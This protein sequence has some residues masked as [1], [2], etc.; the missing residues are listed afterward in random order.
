MGFGKIAVA[1][2]AAAA[3]ELA[4]YQVAVVAPTTV[5]ARQHL[6]SVR[7]RFAGAGVRVEGLSRSG[8]TPEG[9]AVREGL[10]DG[11]VQIVVGTQAIASEGVRFA[12]LGLVVIDE[13][14]RFGE[15]HKTKLAG[16]MLEDGAVHALV[17]TATPIPRTMQSALVGLREVNVIATPPVRRKPTRTF[18]L[19]FDPVVVREALLREHRRGGQSFMVCPRIADIG[20]LEG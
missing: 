14:Q 10:A 3:V 18:V 20:R 2:R 4:G 12:R 15:A 5:L 13:E 8:A 19:P 1:L 17:M 16:L 6:D 7:R 9:R 11:S